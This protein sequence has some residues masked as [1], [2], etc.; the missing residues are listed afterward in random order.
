MK[1]GKLREN[2]TSQLSKLGVTYVDLLLIH[3]PF[4]LGKNGFP[5]HE[6]AWLGLEELKR[7]G[8]ALSIG[9]SNYSI[10]D[11]ERTLAVATQPISCNQIEHHPYVYEKSLPLLEFMKAKIITC[12]SYA[13]SQPITK[14]A[15]GP[16]D[17]I[18]ERIATAVSS[19]HGSAVKPGQILLQWNAQLGN[20]VLTT[21]A[22]EWR[23]KEQ[24]TIIPDLTAEEM[25]E[26]TE[27]G[28][29]GG[30]QRTYMP[31]MDL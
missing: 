28:K 18:L 26:I 30:H 11:L 29:A 23:M 3:W 22:K 19:R 16:L 10:K 14:Y 17:P 7:D 5:T 9:V 27:G 21:S 20:V 2:F 8:L 12:V 24:L 6:E 1:G 13:P 31:H 4:E 25:K 15:G